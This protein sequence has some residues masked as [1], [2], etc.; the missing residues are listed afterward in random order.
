MRNELSVL[1][2]HKKADR[3]EMN[4]D[5]ASVEKVILVKVVVRMYYIVWIV[6]EDA[7]NHAGNGWGSK[8]LLLKSLLD[9]ESLQIHVKPTIMLPEKVEFQMLH[10]FIELNWIS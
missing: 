6:L 9:R 7:F 2:E 3:G 10:V 8:R 4:E 5:K 1:Q